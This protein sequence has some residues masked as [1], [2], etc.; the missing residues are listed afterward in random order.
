MGLLETP[1]VN[2][3]FYFMD[4]GF[5]VSINNKRQ[6]YNP[7]NENTDQKDLKKI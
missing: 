3:K 4:W 5:T 7:I 2:L 1:L 6:K